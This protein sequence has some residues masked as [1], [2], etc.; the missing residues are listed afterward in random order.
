MDFNRRNFLK[1]VSLAAFAGAAAPS[2]LVA[3][4][5]TLVAPIMG[6]A[7]GT[8][9]ALA[10]EKGVLPRGLYTDKALLKELQKRLMDDDCSLPHL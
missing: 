5:T 9:A 8:A 7:V 1:G 10:V 6:Q 3:E 2:R 4:G